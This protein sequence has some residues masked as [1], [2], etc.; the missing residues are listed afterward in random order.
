MI[1]IDDFFSD[2]IAEEYAE[3]ILP[4]IKKRYQ[5]NKSEL[6]YKT[7][8]KIFLDDADNYSE[9]KVKELITLSRKELF[10]KNAFCR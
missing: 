3:K 7:K 1:K 4:E 10:R 9:E 8:K 6:S 5:E 2:K